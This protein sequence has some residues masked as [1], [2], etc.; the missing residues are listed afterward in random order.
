M[1][2]DPPPTTT[3]CR[4]SSARCRW[5]CRSR[6]TPQHSPGS[7]HTFRFR[8]WWLWCPWLGTRSKRRSWRNAL[9]CYTNLNEIIGEQIPPCS[10]VSSRS[11][12]TP[13]GALRRGQT[14]SIS[15]S[16]TERKFTFLLNLSNLFTSFP[17][18]AK[19]LSLVHGSFLKVT[20]LK[21]EKTRKEPCVRRTTSM[22]V[23]QFLHLS[24][25]LA[26]RP[27]QSSQG[28][29]RRSYPGQKS[30][31]C[32]SWARVKMIKCLSCPFR[33]L[34]PGCEYIY[35]LKTNLG[36]PSAKAEKARAR[37]RRYGNLGITDFDKLWSLSQPAFQQR[38]KRDAWD[39][40]MHGRRRQEGELQLHQRP[41]SA[42][43][44]PLGMCTRIEQLRNRTNVGP[45]TG[46]RMQLS[47]RNLLM[48]FLE[49]S[50]PELLLRV[51]IWYA[52]GGDTNTSVS[53][54]SSASI[55]SVVL[56]GLNTLITLTVSSKFH[57]L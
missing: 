18:P 48:K 13:G 51:T 31:S 28:R 5:R 32:V 34:L 57:C 17:Y 36:S 41:P 29:R 4:R 3:Y 26:S 30:W 49:T 27:L 37:T 25:P 23:H 12:S 2:E 46:P 6:Y 20:M 47:L 43:A 42:P 56:K 7:G 55:F 19:T 14:C 38:L 45:E 24:L 54:I 39:A 21:R 11:S 8:R 9:Y 53:T 1:E 15:P 44:R 16:R 52:H 22:H 50:F 40:P 10:A 35:V 33:C